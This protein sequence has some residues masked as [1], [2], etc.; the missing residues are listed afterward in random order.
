MESLTQVADPAAPVDVSSRA[1]DSDEHKND[2]VDDGTRLSNEDSQGN[3]RQDEGVGDVIR[4]RNQDKDE[5]EDKR[6]GALALAHLFGP[7]SSNYTKFSI[8]RA[9]FNTVQAFLTRQGAKGSSNDTKDTGQKVFC[10]YL[11]LRGL[12]CDVGLDMASVQRAMFAA[13]VPTQFE[14]GIAP[15]EV[16]CALGPVGGDI[17]MKNEGR[18]LVMFHEVS[19]I[20]PF[21]SNTIWLLTLSRD[22][23]TL[24]FR[25]L[26]DRIKRNWILFSTLSSVP[27][28][29]PSNG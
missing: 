17:W 7:S 14:E 18:D 29:T 25:A 8:S 3:G 5:I 6:R 20:T 2:Q 24:P 10:Q 4:F 21:S 23:I 28:K 26:R 15:N 16:V 22:S 1:D 12:G 13:N 19:G 27:R 9:F 11:G